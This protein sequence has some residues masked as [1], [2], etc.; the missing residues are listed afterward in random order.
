MY[1]FEAVITDF[2][3]LIRLA[4][5][6]RPRCGSLHIPEQNISLVIPQNSTCFNRRES[7]SYPTNQSR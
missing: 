7:V 6:I 1:R 2:I 3:G 4:V 5:N